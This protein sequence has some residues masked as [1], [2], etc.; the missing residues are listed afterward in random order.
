MNSLEVSLVLLCPH[1]AKSLTPLHIAQVN[2]F[3]LLFAFSFLVGFYFFFSERISSYLNLLLGIKFLLAPVFLILS[4]C[5]TSL[6]SNSLTPS[7][8]SLFYVLTN[9]VVSG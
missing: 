6:I 2:L 3:L 7:E 9:T 5:D 8:L 1:L 4:A